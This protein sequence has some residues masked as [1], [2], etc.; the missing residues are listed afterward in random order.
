MT[1]SLRSVRTVRWTVLVA[2]LTVG[3]ATSSSDTV[4]TDPSPVT[5]AKV[6]SDTHTGSSSARTSDASESSSADTA[7]PGVVPEGFD[8]T[9]AR[10]TSPD[11]TVCELCV[12][13]ADT[14]PQR[15]RGL[16]FVTDLGAADAMAFRYPEPH[17]GTFWMKNT[18]LPLSIAFFAPDGVFL[19]S[20]DMEPCVTETCSNYRTPDDFA[21]AVEVPQGDLDDLGLV[22]G[23]TFELLD[24]PCTT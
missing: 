8:T 20:F 1:R 3:C 19:A 10:A 23:A 2:V 4:P 11:G 12:W 16:M 24:L 21:I 6:A 22:D 9:L 13:L 14:A 18:L 17:T 5:D 15:S 7:T